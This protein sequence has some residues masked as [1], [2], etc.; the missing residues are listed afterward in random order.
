MR[1]ILKEQTAGEVVTPIQKPQPAAGSEPAVPKPAPAAPVSPQNPA[2]AAAKPAVAPAQAAQTIQPRPAFTP[3]VEPETPRFAVAGPA[4]TRSRHRK[5]LASFVAAV[6]LPTV[7]VGG[8]LFAFAQDQFASNLGFS[9]RREDMSSAVD[10]LG[11]LTKLSGSSSTPDYMILYKY[12][13]SRDIIEAVEA[14][15]DVKK[16][17]YSET[18]PYFSLAQD[19]TIEE[20][21]D[22]WRSMVKIYLDSSSGLIEV[23]ARAFD[24]DSARQITTAIRDESAKLLNK[25]SDIAKADATRYS[26]D[27][28]ELQKVRL[29][30][31][32]ER[33]TEFR[34]R[35]QIVDP[36]TDI[37]GRMGL[38]NSLIAE[39][40]TALIDLDMLEGTSATNDP[41][42]EQAKRRIDVIGARI[43]AER[44][45]VSL[46]DAPGKESYAD[47]VSEYEQLSLEQEFAQRSYVAALAA[48]DS[49]LASAQRATRYIATYLPPT[50]AE[51]SEYP[52]RSLLTA[53]TLGALIL[54]W[55]IVV[56]TYYSIRDRR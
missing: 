26:K 24:P 36:E 10:L 4:R 39:Q 43:E 13:Q 48:Y 28:L 19:A 3:I 46:S 17:F 54:I 50:L 12:I 6:I 7:L 16:A 56:L 14:R 5:V 33:L 53:M 41:R 8:Y 20:R 44:K 34:T 45:R 27:E 52:N 51:E 11:G 40:A 2:A 18:D 29:A 21:E 38:L 42:R 23:Q 49:S 32:R 47:L 1:T 25:L 37:Q 55:S 15:I 22:H 35:N 30:T 31:A 9:I